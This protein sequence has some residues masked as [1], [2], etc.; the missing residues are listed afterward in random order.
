[1]NLVAY[2]IENVMGTLQAVQ[3]ELLKTATSN[4]PLS[5]HSR[6]LMD[7][8]FGKAFKDSPR[9][10]KISMSSFYDIYRH[11]NLVSGKKN[12]E[13]SYTHERCGAITR[14]SSSK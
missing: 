12:R 7:N 3:R 10:A 9:R 1:V 5:A 13:S 4:P 8:F 14:R 2:N 6:L 11:T